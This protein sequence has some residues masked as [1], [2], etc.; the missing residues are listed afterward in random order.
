MDKPTDWVSNLVIAA[1]KN[2]KM[3]LCL[4]P[5][6]LNK[7]IKHQHYYMPTA[8]DVQ[9]DMSGKTIYTILYMADGFG[10]YN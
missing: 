3:W 10:T 9:R 6:Q 2:G 8:A 5:K 1:K 7:A 4:D